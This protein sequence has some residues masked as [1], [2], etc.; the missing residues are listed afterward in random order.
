MTNHYV[1]H[2]KLM[3]YYMSTLIEKKINLIILKIQKIGS[4]WDAAFDDGI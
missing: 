2:L 1:I 4:V 3:E